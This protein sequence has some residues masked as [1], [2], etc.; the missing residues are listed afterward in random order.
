MKDSNF[1]ELLHFCM[2][3]PAFH[4]GSTTILFAFN[5]KRYGYVYAAL[6]FISDASTLGMI[7]YKLPHQT[8]INTLLLKQ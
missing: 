3:K 2:A 1:A 5:L 4:H 6:L 8:I 7:N